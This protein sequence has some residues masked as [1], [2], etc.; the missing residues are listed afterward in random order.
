MLDVGVVA[1]VDFDGSG[2]VAA[3]RGGRWLAPSP[4][5]SVVESA[6]VAAS[7]VDDDGTACSSASLLVLGKALTFLCPVDGVYSA[8][9]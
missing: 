8:A 9:V 6:T 3:W 2:T 5:S 7:D 4:E 1:D